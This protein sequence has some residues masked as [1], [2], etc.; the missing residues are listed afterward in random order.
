MKP[1]FRPSL[2][3]VCNSAPDLDGLDILGKSP[4]QNALEKFNITFAK[5]LA[6]AGCQIDGGSR[7][8]RLKRFGHH[9]HG[10]HG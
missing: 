10:W 6:E 5:I 7:L 9:G 2:L 8:E 3:I 1:E 4:F